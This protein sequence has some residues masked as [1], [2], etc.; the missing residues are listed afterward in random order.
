[1]KDDYQPW[2][3]WEFEEAE[4]LKELDNAKRKVDLSL[5]RSQQGQE[6][7]NLCDSSKSEGGPSGD[8]GKQK[9]VKRKP[10]RPPKGK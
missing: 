9:E 5:P 4:R 2:D 10:G 7:Q 8:H 1:M 3:I 6:V